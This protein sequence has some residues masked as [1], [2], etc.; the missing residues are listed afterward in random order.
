MLQLLQS[1]CTG[2]HFSFFINTIVFMH[3]PILVLIVLLPWLL[4]SCYKKEGAVLQSTL[5]I[6]YP[7]GSALSFFDNRLYLVG[8]DATTVLVMDEQF[9]VLGKIRISS[10]LSNRIPK[11]IKRDIEGMTVIRQGKNSSLLL[12]GSGSLAPY[13]NFGQVVTPG[14]NFRSTYDLGSFYRRLQSAGIA[15][16]NIEG[17]AAMPGSIILASRGSKGFPRNHLVFAQ[18]D[19]Y[20]QADSATFSIVR[21]G[22]NSDTAVFNGISGLEYAA[23]SDKLLM[24]VSTENTYNSYSDGTIGKSYLW[25]INDVSTRKRISHLNPDRI[26]DLEALDPVFA[27]HKIESVCI[28]KETRNEFV[29]VLAADDDKGQTLLFKLRLKK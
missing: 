1:I 26:I 24:T 5:L 7:S 29:L 23:S 20:R 28:I 16:V 18:P 15:Q 27:G 8:D 2:L 17:A 25:I 22:T 21:V 3:R 13:R 12:V 6:D 9:S 14:S 11:K 10:H 4:F 19:F